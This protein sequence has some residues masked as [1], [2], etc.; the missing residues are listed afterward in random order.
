MNHI[1]TPNKMRNSLTRMKNDTLKRGATRP[2]L[3]R[4]AFIDRI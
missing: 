4:A 1:I 3:E 2:E